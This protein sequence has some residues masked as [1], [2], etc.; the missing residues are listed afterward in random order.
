VAY[1][2]DDHSTVNIILKHPDLPEMQKISY[3]DV[4]LGKESVDMGT[5]LG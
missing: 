2:E 5:A 3:S 4:T 1:P